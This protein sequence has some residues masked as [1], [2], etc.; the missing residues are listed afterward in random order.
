MPTRT[1]PR[2]E[3]YSRVDEHVRK[4]DRPG[5]DP[6]VLSG[7]VAG[8]SEET[9]RLFDSGRTLAQDGTGPRREE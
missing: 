9:A 5:T 6:K 3:R 2:V 1:D 8:T 7:A 4:L